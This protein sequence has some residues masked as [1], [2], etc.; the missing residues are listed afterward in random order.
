MGYLKRLGSRKYDLIVMSGDGG[1][2]RSFNFRMRTV[3]VVALVAVL[4]L[5]GLIVTLVLYAGRLEGYGGLVAQNRRL[6]V[7]RDHVRQTVLDTD[8]HGL[9]SAGLV[10]ELLGPLRA[11]LGSSAE[12]AREDRAGG[13]L[14]DGYY[15][16]FLDNVPTLPP[17][18]GFVTRGLLL[19]ELNMQARYNGIDIA[20]VSGAVIQA[21]AAGLVV[22]A[23]WTDD[24]GN[25]VIIS[26]GDNY[27]T[28]YGHNQVNL[29]DQRE[30]VERGQPIALVGSTGMSQAP[31][32]HFEIWKDAR[33]I[34]PRALMDLY[35]RQDISVDTDG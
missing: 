22:F 19:R 4:G 12:G 25:L 13:M 11:S 33:S 32:L 35:R 18:D 17:V 6:Q 31:H 7:Y 5:S 23:N 16:N 14:F 21:S 29:V 30:R 27:Y 26:H 20:A 34:D 8:R 28:V 1:W 24:L 3:A 15:L 9:L 2:T 10:Q